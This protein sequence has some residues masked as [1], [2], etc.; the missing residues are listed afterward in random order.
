MQHAKTLSAGEQA[1]LLAVIASTRHV[2]R[3]RVIVLLSVKAGLR[4]NE[5]AQL[6]WSMVLTASGDIADSITIPGFIAKYGRG[7]R[8]P[9][10]GALAKALAALAKREDR[11]GP[12]VKS[13]RKTAM[14]GK[15]I[16]NWFACQYRRAELQGCSS[17]SGRRTFVTQAARL[18]PKV[19]GSLRDVQQLAGH[20]SIQT[21]QLYIDGDTE[22]QRQLVMAM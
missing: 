8:I 10:H 6:Q 17:H 15:T 9:M 20:R 21:T 12:V 7:R 16:V 5:I 18:L 19:G 22:A 13:E 3:N 2:E 1:R 4:A 14:S 11:V